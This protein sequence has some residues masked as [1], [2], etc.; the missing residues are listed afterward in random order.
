MKTARLSTKLIAGFILIALIGCTIGIF[1]IFNIKKI[2][3]LDTELYEAN[4]Q[5]LSVLLEISTLYQRSRVNLREVV[6]SGFEHKD[7]GE[8]VRK[9]AD[10]DSKMDGYLKEFEK[11]IKSDEVRQI[12]A[13]L[14]NGV[15]QYEPVSQKVITLVQAGKPDEAMAMVHGEGQAIAQAIDQ[16]I[17]KLADLK[18][19]QAKTKSDNNTATANAS[20]T[21]TT[22]LLV[23]GLIISGF[24]GFF[25][26]R[27]ITGPINLVAAG[28]TDGAAQVSAAAQQVSSSSQQMAEGTSEQ[29]A[30]LEEASSSLD[31]MSSMTRQN[32]DHAAHAKSMMAEMNQ[33]LEKVNRQMTEMAAAMIEI[34]SASEET[35]KIIKTIDEIAFQTNL[36][37]LNAA[38]EAA[39]A[40]EAGAGF[41]VV[42]DEV[43]NLA[44]R[45]SE[46]A[47]NTN[48]LIENTIKSVH[49]GRQLTEMTQNAFKENVEKSQKVTQLIDEIAQASGEQ[50]Q[51]ISQVNIAV[52]EIGKVTQMT[53]ANGEESAA[54]SEEL[55]AQAEQ[56]KV[57]VSDLVAIIN[58]SGNGTPID[59]AAVPGVGIRHL[60]KA[61][62][63]ALA[64]ATRRHDSLAGGKRKALAGK[65]VSPEEILPMD[66]ANEEW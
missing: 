25:I 55:S 14:L 63:K 43:R 21:I 20:T 66:R 17:Q 53:A 5:P 62:V 22:I 40:G 10:L 37:A 35:G 19:T 28:L 15:H 38:V 18:S 57:Y 56:M 39:R 52:G 33:V 8:Y 61:P 48:S 26:T 58:G 3:N 60:T 45:A 42:A 54:A 13:A 65:V 9:I 44:M 41:A 30:S 36:L 11:S 4:T 29:A 46:A 31:E 1:G 16:N 50:S 59:M 49:N 24:L 51:G 6:I 27:S 7:S 32:A 2:D 12:H 23:V 34:T 47:K 64:A